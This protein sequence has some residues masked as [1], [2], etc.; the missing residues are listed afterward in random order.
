MVT[1]AL[2]VLFI[3]I[4]AG[5]ILH[6]R[7]F[8]YLAVFLAMVFGEARY[9]LK[10]V[11]LVIVFL[12]PLLPRLG[13]A[14]E[15][16]NATITPLYII[17]PP[18]E[19]MLLFLFLQWFV[20]MGQGRAGPLAPRPL[21]SPLLVFF[22]IASCSAVLA[23]ITRAW[24][25]EAPLS[26]L[27]PDALV[28]R[29][30]ALSPLF[31]YRVLFTFLESFL[32]Y[33]FIRANFDREEI[34]GIA[35]ALLVSG[36]AVVFIG[37]VD[38]V[39]HDRAE[40]YHGTNRAISVFSGP[41]SFATYLLLVLPLA[42]AFAVTARQRV[43]RA[44]AGL[45]L[46]GGLPMLY[47]THSNGAFFAVAATLLLHG[48]FFRK[49]PPALSRAARRAILLAVLVGL[50]G[51]SVLLGATKTATQ[52][53]DL[54]HGRYFLAL[55]ALNM[56]KASPLVGVGLGNYYHHLGGFY[57][58]GIDSPKQHTHAHSLYLQLLSELGPAGLVLFLVPFVRLFRQSARAPRL[59]PMAHAALFGIIAVLL[60]CV[61]DY[62]LYIVPVSLLF[63]T[64][65]GVLAT[66]LQSSSAPG[67]WS[68]SAS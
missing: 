37:I 27:E 23:S 30:P 17:S 13:L 18:L 25:A 49:G 35:R 36:C 1:W 3:A 42:V 45:V 4:I 6:A 46:L 57:P 19:I 2:A 52:I 65:V 50:A 38:F 48:L 21:V 51:G 43:I 62:T 10:R 22:V 34:D 9:G 56:F 68:S 60:Q 47:L 39:T 15:V 66:L 16:H 20:R 40:Y 33:R 53:N 64:Y 32:L 26:G 61:S 11:F 44:A 59:L 12:I 14:K 55:A 24:T 41:G 54:T 8:W 7:H 31:P 63:W 5:H 28:F 58:A 29:N 67:A